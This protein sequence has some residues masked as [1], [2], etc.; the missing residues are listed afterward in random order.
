MCVIF[1]FSIWKE[2]YDDQ[3][4]NIIEYLPAR[5]QMR[6][7]LLLCFLFLFVLFWG[8]FLLGENNRNNVVN[9]WNQH[10]M[11][12]ILLQC[13]KFD[14]HRLAIANDI[15]IA[16]FVN[17]NN[18]LNLISDRQKSNKTK[19]KW[20]LSHRKKKIIVISSA[21]PSPFSLKWNEKENHRGRHHH[22]HHHQ[23]KLKRKRRVVAFFFVRNN[24]FYWLLMNCECL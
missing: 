13:K 4:H 16:H 14:F 5:I 6:F 21:Q 10:A 8:R 7:D 22:H 19:K 15:F 9:V 24:N 11:L 23:P 2:I 18:I 20:F 3:H 12:G 17:S 1:F